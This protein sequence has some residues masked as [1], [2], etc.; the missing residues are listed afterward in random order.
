MAETNPIFDKHYDAYLKAIA[1]ID[2]S[3]RI[4]ILDISLEKDGK[5]AIV[6][7]F[8][9]RYRVSS[10]GVVDPA[11]NRPDYGTCVV[12]LKYLLMCPAQL[13]LETDWVNYRDLKDSGPLTVY[14]SNHILGA[15]S[16]GF[17]GRR[18]ILAAAATAFG[19]S[20]PPI[21]Y[22]YDVAA[23]FRG[24]PRIPLLL[25]FNDVDDEFAAQTTILFERRAEL[26]LDAE[27]L[28]M[29]GGYLTKNL[30]G[31]APDS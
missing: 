1:G 8:D 9:K 2:L 22:P 23:A 27:C 24:L 13:P 10:A 5:T 19:G 3:Q 30:R 4:T 21:A 11:G 29:L 17:T 25:L 28:A 6:P 15:I 12:L 14:F 31:P 26:F 16:R 20:P 18:E 7:F